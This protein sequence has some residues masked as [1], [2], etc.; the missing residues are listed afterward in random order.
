M[1]NQNVKERLSKKIQRYLEQ[2]CD[3]ESMGDYKRAEK[4]FWTGLHREGQLRADITN[5][6]E[7]A[8]AVGPVYQETIEKRLAKS[9]VQQI[10]VKCTSRVRKQIVRN[11]S[12][13][14]KSRVNPVRAKR[15]CK[16]LNELKKS[17]SLAKVQSQSKPVRKDSHIETTESVLKVAESPSRIKEFILSMLSK[18]KA[19]FASIRQRFCFGFGTNHVNQPVVS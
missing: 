15:A 19:G 7:Y 16:I 11:L 8:D 3:A 18:I 9:Q 10:A 14:S 13:A 5:P 4:L 1:M 2:A 6:K 12:R 17:E